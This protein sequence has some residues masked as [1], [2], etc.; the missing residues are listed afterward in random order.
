MLNDFNGQLTVCVCPIRTYPTN[1]HQPIWN[2]SKWEV[3][4]M[5]KWPYIIVERLNP[6]TEGICY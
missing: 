5:H 2:R 1:Q 3:W 6:L 4:H